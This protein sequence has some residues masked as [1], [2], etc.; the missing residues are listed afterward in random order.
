LTGGGVTDR[1]AK[2]I[3]AGGGWKRH[4]S[5]DGREYEVDVRKC[6]QDKHHVEDY[7]NAFA[8]RK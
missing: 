3:A 7:A 8:E 1:R 5:D 4:P 2:R 6:Q